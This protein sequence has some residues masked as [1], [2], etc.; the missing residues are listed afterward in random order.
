MI[1][2]LLSQSSP[3]FDRLIAVLEAAEVA[4]VAA[5]E[6]A[7]KKLEAAQ[8]HIENQLG[9]MLDWM[10]ESSRPLLEH[11]EKVKRRARRQAQEQPQRGGRATGGAGASTPIS[12]RGVRLDPIA[13]K[14]SAPNA[15]QDSPKAGKAGVKTR[16]VKKGVGNGPV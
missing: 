5:R 9:L 11:A 6:D 10:D 1:S 8:S 7:A 3:V 15:V 4:K 14:T 12:N 16:G 13:T 2:E